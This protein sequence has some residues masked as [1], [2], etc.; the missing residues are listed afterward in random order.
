LWAQQPALAGTEVKLGSISVDFAS[1][2]SAGSN[3][4]WTDGDS[5][6]LSGNVSYSYVSSTL[7][8]SNRFGVLNSWGSGMSSDNPFLHVNIGQKQAEKWRPTPPL[9]CPAG[10]FIYVITEGAGL[11][12]NVRRL[13][14]RGNERVSDA[15]TSVGGLSQVSG[16]KMWVARPSPRETDK[17]TILTVDWP[18]IARH[19][20]ATN[21]ALLPGDRLVIQS[22]ATIARS[23]VISNHTSRVERLTGIVAATASTIQGL[24]DTPGGAAAVREVV[25]RGVFDD[26]PELKSAV[27]EMIRISEEPGK[28]SAKATTGGKQGR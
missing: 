21:H 28:Q 4:E 2:R 20:D 5:L 10:Q 23:N 25:R 24:R 16:T 8:I 18:Q 27:E 12:D 14:W 17:S 7:T 1:G 22:D 9:I 15:I 3:I 11:G 19:D 26:A 6:S 13:P